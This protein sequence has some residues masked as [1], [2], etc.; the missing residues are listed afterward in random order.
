MLFALRTRAIGLLA[1]QVQLA[2]GLGADGVVL[3]GASSDYHGSGCA[4]VAGELSDFAGD[5]MDE[6]V[7][8]RIACSAAKCSGH[9]RCIDYSEAAL[10]QTC[11]ESSSAK[12]V[13]VTCRCD[14]GYSGPSCAE[15]R[16][17]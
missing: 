10:L 16:S 3:W 4:M 14:P 11:L 1:T 2:A 15:S 5:T 12:R 9:G 13:T 7:H 8:N 6:C 17:K